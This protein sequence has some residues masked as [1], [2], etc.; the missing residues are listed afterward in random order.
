MKLKNL[1]LFLASAIIVILSSCGGKMSSYTYNE[2]I[3]AMHDKASDY[4]N[5]KMETIYEHQISKEEA[6]RIVDTMKMKY[7][8]YIKEL[9]TM[10]I[11]DKAEDWNN[12][13]IQLYT[14]VRDSVIPLYSET[15]NFEP[16]SKDWYKVWNQIDDRLKGRASQIE[17]QVIIEQQKFAAATNSKLK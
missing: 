1:F 4:L 7:D 3:V 16:E 15:L 2:R 11:P 13:C 8:G 5:T 12:S 10:K 14:Y 9:T 17:D 6:S